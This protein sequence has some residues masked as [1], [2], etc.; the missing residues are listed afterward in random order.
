MTPAVDEPVGHVLGHG[1]GRCDHADRGTGLAA[2]A[3]SSS[4]WR[5]LTPADLLADARRVDVDQADD[6]KAP[7]AEALVVGQRV[8]EVAEAHDDDRPVVGQ[9]ELAA[10]LEEQELDVVAHAAG[11]EAAEI[12][13][14]PC[15]PWRR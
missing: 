15:G 1:R 2:I 11:A 13:T 8:A 6:L 10:D 4:R 12:A 14:G 9:A 5:T 3:G 7:G